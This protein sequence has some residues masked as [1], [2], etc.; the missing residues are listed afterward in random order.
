MIQTGRLLQVVAHPALLEVP[1]AL[2]ERPEPTKEVG[3]DR[4]LR[5]VEVRSNLLRA[6]PLLE[7]ERDRRPVL[8]W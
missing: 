3:T 1:H 5:K 7:T 4:P 8:V 6:Q 2:L